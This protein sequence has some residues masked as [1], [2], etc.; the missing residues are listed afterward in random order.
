M[1]LKHRSALVVGAGRGIGEAVRH[2]LVADGMIVTGTYRSSPFVDGQGS[3]LYLDLSRLSDSALRA[4][5]TSGPFDALVYCAGVALP[6]APLLRWSEERLEE[7][8][9]VNIH[10]LIS[11]LQIVTAD[12]IRARFG[13]IIV[14]SSIAGIRGM[15]LNGP[16]AAS[17]AGQVALVKSM[18]A[19]LRAH[20][21]TVNA[22]CPGIVRTNMAETV[23]RFVSPT[24]IAEPSAIADLI[25]LLVQ[26]RAGNITGA[27]IEIGFGSE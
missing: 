27:A 1:T 8:W 24:R 25:S 4:L 19:E 9:S 11:V 22:V 26:E 5:R 10:G 15:P 7:L 23:T 3:P 12:M 13:R 20:G 17:K 21:I 18:A 6:A 14:V 2:R 16:Y